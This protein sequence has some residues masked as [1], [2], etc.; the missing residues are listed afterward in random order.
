MKPVLLAFFSLLTALVFAQP[1]SVKPVEAEHKTSF[2]QYELLIM[3]VVGLAL[4][5]GIR[6]WFKRTRKR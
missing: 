4:L 3:A 2:E 5:M 1:N 6:Y